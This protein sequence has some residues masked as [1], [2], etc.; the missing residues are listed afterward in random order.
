MNYI[1]ET[2]KPGIKEQIVEMVHNGAGVRD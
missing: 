2:R 1:Y